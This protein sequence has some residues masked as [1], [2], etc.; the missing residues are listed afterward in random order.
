MNCQDIREKYTSISESIVRID[1]EIKAIQLTEQDLTEKEAK[2]MDAI[3]A[4]T[5]CLEIHTN[6]YKTVAGLLDIQRQLKEVYSE[7]FTNFL[8]DQAARLQKLL[9]EKDI[10]IKNRETI[11]SFFRD[12]NNTMT[13][14]DKSK[15]SP[16]I[17]GVCYE[18]HINRVCVPCG[19]VFCDGCVPK[20]RGKCA[21]CNINYD[22][23]IKL[24][25]NT[26][27]DMV[28]S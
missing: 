15:L 1:S 21:S 24:F 20:L 10:L 26:A 18:N 13:E 23:V 16:N 12:V 27:S 5:V 22:T 14:D 4:F 6:N 9:N 11:L 8:Q 17:C 25:M 19:H 28:G 7:E 2:C 3:H